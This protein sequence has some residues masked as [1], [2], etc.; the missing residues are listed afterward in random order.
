MKIPPEHDDRG[1]IVQDI[2]DRD[3]PASERAR[4]SPQN[5][6]GDQIH[7]R[8]ADN[9]PEL[10][11]LAAI[12]EAGVGR[13]HF[14]LAADSVAEVAHPA[15]VGGASTS[16]AAIQ[17]S[18]CSPKKITNPSPNQGCSARRERSAAE[19]RSEPA[20]QPRQINAEAGEQREE[21]EESDHPMQKARVHAVTLQL[22]NV[23]FVLPDP[24]EGVARFVVETFNWRW[25]SDPSFFS[26]GSGCGTARSD[27]HVVQQ[28][29][30]QTEQREGAKHRLEQPLPDRIAPRDDRVLRQAAVAFRILG[31][32]Q[33]VNDVRAADGL[34]IVD[35]G[36]FQIR[37]SREVVWRVLRRCTSC[38]PWC[39]TS[40]IP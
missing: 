3:C 31:V 34:W 21:K 1:N 28:N 15:S 5:N 38:R 37:N 32:V 17:F 27:G 33:N 35:A 8:P 6:S 10:R 39:R 12:E 18:T 40:G 9:L 19:D 24:I 36:V 20:K 11:F 16:S 26:G 14:F 22:A 7:D 13:F 29:S 23:D 30:D 25:T 2:A 4:S